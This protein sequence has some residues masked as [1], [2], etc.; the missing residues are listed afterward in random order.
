[1]AAEPTNDASETTG[2]AGLVCGC[3]VQYD[4]SGV[5]H[6][7]RNK[8]A[9]EIPATVREE[10]EAEIINGGVTECDDYVASNGCHYRWY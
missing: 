6:C 10:I 5:G 1:M 9:D 3:Q 7:W 4:A 8:R 2:D